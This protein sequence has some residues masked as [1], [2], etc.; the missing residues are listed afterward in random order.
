MLRFNCRIFVPLYLSIILPGTP[1]LA[2]PLDRKTAVISLTKTLAD[3]FAFAETYKKGWA[4][5]C[6]ALLE[7]LLSP[8]VPSTTDDLIADHDVDD[9]SFGVGFTQLTTIKRPAQDPWPDITNMK[10]W[11]MEY[12]NSVNARENGKIVKYAKERLSPEELRSL[13]MYIQ[14]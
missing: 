1:K 10:S 8:P 9:M 14:I 13:A 4:F 12:L 7:L 2:R 3:S 6:N 5:T 11:V